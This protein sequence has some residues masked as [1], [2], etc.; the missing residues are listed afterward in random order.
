MRQRGAPHHPCQPSTRGKAPASQ[1]SE[2]PIDFEYL[3]GVCLEE[4]L[5]L[6]AQ[7]QEL[8]ALVLEA[9]APEEGASPDSDSDSDS[10]LSDFTRD[11]YVQL[12]ASRSSDSPSSEKAPWK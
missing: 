10:G 6:E 7:F 1:A 5:A 12:E 9:Y 2:V 4:L 11:Y 8:L 3:A